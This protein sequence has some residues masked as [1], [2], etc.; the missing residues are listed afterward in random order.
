MNSL[1][2]K[3]KHPLFIVGI[4]ILSMTFY[5]CKKKTSEYKEP[6]NCISDSMFKI[7]S[8]DTIKIRTLK[9]D[10]RLTGKISF[11][12]DKVIRLYTPVGG[13]VDKVTVSIGD[14]VQKG[15]II[16]EI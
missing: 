15:Q 3:F 4:L 13:I 5:G 1:L 6:S 8:F 14:F 9:E 11:N 2:Y 7:L 10:I 16:A 12:E